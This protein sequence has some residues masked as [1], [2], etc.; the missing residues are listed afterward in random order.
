LD[1]LPSREE[2]YLMLK[3]LREASEGKLFLEKEF[4]DCTVWLCRMLEEDG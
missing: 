1:A 4:A 3:M 2:K